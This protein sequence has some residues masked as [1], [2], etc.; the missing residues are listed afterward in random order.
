MTIL[1]VNENDENQTIFNFIKKNYK[2]TNLSVIYK[3][4]RTN[5]VKINEK[6]IK[7][8]KVV[9]KKGDVVKIYDS[10]N[11]S[12]RLVVELVDYSNL[13]I[14]YEDQ[15]IIIVDKPAGLEIHSPINISLDQI[16]RSYLIDTK[17]YDVDLENSFVIS[18]VHRLDKLT[19]GLVIYAKNKASLNTLLTAIKNKDM[20]KKF[21]KAKLESNKIN[22]GL[23]Q[24]YINYDSEIQKANFILNNKRN[25][26]KCSQI[27]KWIDKENNIL[28]VNLLSGRKHQ[29]R[30]VCEFFN[31][32]I[33]NDFRYGAQRTSKKE[34]SLIAYKLVFDNFSNFL[35]YLNGKEF[36]SKIDF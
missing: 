34:I 7:D 18:H 27:H 16:V 28:E 15:N 8:Q 30:A 19:K 36:Y 23:I 33:E 12:K 26:K 31:A 17:Q 35:S 13:E 4:F 20:I 24:G 2:T 9:L 6:K 14:I 3:W 22:L 32:S 25:Y 29:I 21:Y 11:I 1:N 5:K 10:A